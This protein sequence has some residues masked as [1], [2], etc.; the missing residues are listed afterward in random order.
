ML[1]FHRNAMGGSPGAEF[2][3]ELL[4]EVSDDELWHRN[5]VLSMI[6]VRKGILP[7]SPLFPDL[8]SHSGWTGQ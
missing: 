7:G 3:N 2:A 1:F 6:T 5:S 4:L 8:L